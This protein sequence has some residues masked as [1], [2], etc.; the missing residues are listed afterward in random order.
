MMATE[1]IGQR[2]ARQFRRATSTHAF[3]VGQRVTLKRG[4]GGM[5]SP[6]DIYHITGTLPPQGNSPQYRI[7]NDQ[8]C[9]ERVTAQD[10][11]RPVSMTQSG[12]SLIARTFGHGKETESKQSR[13]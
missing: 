8:E 3:A 9:H 12:P 11:L 10:D 6:A 1:T 13:D 4:L 5:S 7:R 2:H